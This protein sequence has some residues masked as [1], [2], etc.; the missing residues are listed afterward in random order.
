MCKIEITFWKYSTPLRWK[1]NKADLVFELAQLINDNQKNLYWSPDM[2]AVEDEFSTFK[3]FI[4][5]T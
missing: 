4:F 1:M 2:H 3:N 5:K